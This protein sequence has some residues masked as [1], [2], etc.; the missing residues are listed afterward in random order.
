M[1]AIVQEN[2]KAIGIESDAERH[3]GEVLRDHGRRR[4]PLLPGR[5]VRRLPDVRQLHGTTCT[6]APPSAATTSGRSTTPTF[7]DLV[8]QAQAEP[9]DEKRADLYRQAETYLLNDA[10]GTVPI[11]WYNGDQ[12][13]ADNVTGYEQPPLGII[14]WENVGLKAS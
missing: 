1:V 5:L 3:L 4:L 12:V 14:L 6:A 7:D 2:L 10:T 11:N 9:D 8:D 13:Y